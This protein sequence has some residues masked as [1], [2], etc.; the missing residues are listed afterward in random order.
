[1]V[2]SSLRCVLILVAISLTAIGGPATASHIPPGSA[3]YTTDLD[4]DDGVLLNVNHD[5][6]NNNQLQLNEVAEPFPFVNVAA[7]ARGTVVRIDV[8]SGAILGEYLTA[9]DGMGRNPSRTT[10]DKLGNVWV[11]NRDEFGGGKGSVARI[12]LVIGGTRAEADGT[13]NPAG[14]YLKP[15]FDYS[16]CI[17]RDA[18]NLIK[19]STG[20]A[21]ILPWSNA[22]GADSNGGVSTA[23][24]ECVINYVR[25]VGTGTR[26][27]AV[28]ANNDLWTGGQDNDHEKLD[29]ATGQP[30]AG[31][32]FNLGCGGYGGLIDGANVL[33]SARFGNNLLRYDATAGTGVCLGTDHGDYGLGIDPTTGEIW[34]SNLSGNRIAKLAPDGTLIAAFS[35]G[36]ENAQGVAVDGVGNV[37]VAH[38]LFGS[39]TVGHLRT[40][41][42]FVGNVALPGGVGP[43][44]VAVDANGKIWVANISTDN[45]QRIDPSG[46]PVGGGGF[47]VG[48]VD[49]T[50]SLGAGAGPYN[51][52]DMTGFVAIGST[53]PSGSWTVIRNGGAPGTQWGT[54]S[55][56]TEPQGSEPPGTSIEVEAR[57]ADTQAGLGSQPFIDVSNAVAFSLTGQFIEVRATLTASASGTSPVLSDISIETTEPPPPECAGEVAT[58]VGTIGDDALVGTP[59]RD[60]IQAL[61]GDDAVLGLGGNDLI[62][63]DEGDDELFGGTGRDRLIGNHDDDSLFGGRGRDELDGGN[64]ADELAGGRGDDTLAG[65]RGRD[66]LVGGADDDELSG[67]AGADDLG[68][69]R[70]DDLAFGGPGTDDLDGGTGDDELS[71]ENGDDDLIGG[72]GDDVLFGGPGEDELFGT[73]GDD[74]LLGESGDDELAGATGNDSLDGGADTDDCDGGFGTD[75]D[76]GCEVLIGFP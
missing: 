30:I 64:G 26:T 3:T 75:T 5:A 33:W 22:A 28:D 27:V 69:G 34:H 51:Y 39:T 62:C 7:S 73:N 70:G 31:T 68:G 11:G 53:T 40:D 8:N 21:N 4:F 6:P 60:V 49:M 1:M 15:P 71:G 59:G 18:D 76:A 65:G 63:G 47:N 36:E 48:A 66:D 25:V 16:T 67:N 19:T 2:K 44:G 74:Q 37:W 55:W 58:I 35:H 29:G 57:A 20:L 14:Q 12:G 13:P 24:D 43:T 41:G 54:I 32:Q 72:R 61:D 23:E 42:T 52:S 17:D 56:N 9:P 38:S 50:V 46:G 45:A 10:V